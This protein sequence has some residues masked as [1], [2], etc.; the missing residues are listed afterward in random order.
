MS[1]FTENE[2]LKRPIGFWI[3]A[4]DRALSAGIDAC[5]RD[6]GLSRRDWQLLNTLADVGGI[7]TVSAMAKDFT[8]MLTEDEVRE[9]INGLEAKGFVA[10]TAETCHGTEAG[11]E[12]HRRASGRQADYRRAAMC[13]ISDADYRTAVKVL[14]V[15]VENCRT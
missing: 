7:M 9:T 12:I 14:A 11:Q 8:P 3:R 5:H 4:A 2:I 10:V 13:G 1:N 15:L 6:L